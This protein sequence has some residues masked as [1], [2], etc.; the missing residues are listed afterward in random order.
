M[1]N[2]FEHPLSVKEFSDIIKSLFSHPDFQDITI[3]GEVYSVKVGRFSYIDLGDSTEEQNKSPII[4]LAFSSYLS[5]TI[6][7]IQVGDII[8]VRGS[9]SYYN[10]GSSITLWGQ[11][12]KILQNQLGKSLL[13]KQEILKRLE[14]EGLLNPER[15]RK[16]P[17]VC[18]RVAILTA[19]SGAAYQD[20]KKTLHDRFPCSTILF[21]TI[22]QGEGARDSIYKN[23]LAAQRE[24]VDCIL[25]GRGGGSKTDLSCFDDEKI[26]RLIC[27]SKVPV[28]TCIGHQIDIS[29]CD[30][31]SDLSAITPTEG[32]S[33]INEPLSQVNERR[34]E[35][36]KKAK[37]A[38]LEFVR[39]KANRLNS[40]HREI[41]AHSP[42][43][44]IT[45]KEKQLIQLKKTVS[46]RLENLLSKRNTAFTL[47]VKKIKQSYQNQ[48]QRRKEEL[49]TL[50]LN[51]KPY[52]PSLV[53]EKGY[54]I[55]LKEGVLVRGIKDLKQGDELML[56]YPDGR[57][58]IKVEEE[59]C[60][61][62]QQ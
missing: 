22:V 33:Y 15:K 21:P 52:D 55:V 43:A 41:E 4:K 9:L 24:D 23:L 5:S 34:E 25:L 42:K 60:Q 26:A 2:L 32:A 40:Y 14:K 51:L 44:M 54:A 53:K 46:L 13:L 1:I 50:L 28:I 8:Q 38:Y 39:E 19:E 20:I 61:E 27:A 11:E 37:Q 56:T 18:K 49:H 12:V 29:I 45:Q 36:K 35:L 7:D 47:L 48:I 6:R 57:V 10:R 58:K 17:K 30:R 16:L 31:V 62:K 59:P 3:Y